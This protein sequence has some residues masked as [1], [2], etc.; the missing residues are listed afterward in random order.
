V[1]AVYSGG[2]CQNCFVTLHYMHEKSMKPIGYIR[3]ETTK[4]GDL[5]RETAKHDS[6]NTN[7]ITSSV[8]IARFFPNSIW[9]FSHQL[10]RFYGNVR[11][12]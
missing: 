2:P 6:E 11:V 9:V 8:T 4:L 5:R 10:G 3:Q 7:S 12:F 1:Y